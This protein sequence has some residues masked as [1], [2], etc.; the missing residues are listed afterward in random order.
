M[1]RRIDYIKPLVLALAGIVTASTAIL[2]ALVAG[3]AS[4]DNDL[5]RLAFAHAMAPMAVAVVVSTAG[6]I[7]LQALRF[8]W[9]QA[10]DFVPDIARKPWSRGAFRAIV[11]ISFLL[12]AW[13]A[14]S[15][16]YHA[17]KYL[18]TGALNVI[19]NKCSER[20]LSPVQRSALPWIL[21]RFYQGGPSGACRSS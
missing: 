4:K 21:R 5:Y 7:V 6:V 14:L 8:V 2:I 19:E 15:P 20:F 13:G 11:G 3:T 12:F 17:A 16:G 18:V 9:Q 1:D 10:P